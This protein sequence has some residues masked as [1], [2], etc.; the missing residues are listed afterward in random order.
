MLNE[1]E[2]QKLKQI[3]VKR[4]KN[5]SMYKLFKEPVYTNF[6]D[7]KADALSCT[8]C[9]L[10]LQVKHIVVGDGNIHAKV[11][12]LGQNPGMTEDKEGKP[13]VGKSGQLLREIFNRTNLNIDKIYITNSILCHTP[14]NRPPSAYELKQCKWPIEII[15]YMKPLLLIPLGL[16]AIR[17]IGIKKDLR[18]AVGHLWHTTKYGFNMYIFP[19]YHP[20][21]VLR[22]SVSKVVYD[23]LFIQLN[24]IIKYHLKIE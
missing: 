8:L 11:L 16:S 19:I 18:D 4:D 13:F 21:A 10:H 5:T 1:K 9:P 22:G 2:P 17:K 6:Q 23:N 15:K 20:A 12:I 3:I 24:D 14:H 7:L